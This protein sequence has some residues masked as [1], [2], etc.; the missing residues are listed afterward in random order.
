[1]AADGG[2][3]AERRGREPAEEDDAER[4]VVREHAA[5]EVGEGCAASAGYQLLLPHD[6]QRRRGCTAPP[7]CAA[8]PA[9]ICSSRG[10]PTPPFSASRHGRPLD[11]PI[12]LLLLAKGEEGGAGETWWDWERRRSVRGLG[13][14][15]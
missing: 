4:E 6:G 12:P 3:G 7:T 9:T 14:G 10:A 13:S 11:L 8:L 1:V 5:A 15:G 2:L